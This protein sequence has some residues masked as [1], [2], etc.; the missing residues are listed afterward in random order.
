MTP[1]LP[2]VPFQETCVSAPPASL[3]RCLSLTG[4]FYISFFLEAFAVDINNQTKSVAS[5][6]LLFL[7][8]YEEPKDLPRQEMPLQTWMSDSPHIPE[9]WHVKPHLHRRGGL[10]G[11]T[12]CVGIGNVIAGHR[13]TYKTERN[14]WSGTTLALGSQRYETVRSSP[15]RHMLLACSV[16]LSVFYG[17]QSNLGISRFLNNSR[18]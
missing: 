2:S 13:N 9:Q 1:P 10:P 17:G 16:C 15:T 12:R 14:L 5:P 4:C 3:P 7:Q 11:N 6:E 18:K 8:V